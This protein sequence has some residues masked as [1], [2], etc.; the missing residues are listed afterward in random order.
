MSEDAASRLRNYSESP[1]WPNTGLKPTDI[2]G[3]LDE[4][5]RVREELES[6]RRV[7]RLHEK[8]ESIDDFD[9][10]AIEAFREATEQRDAY[11]ERFQVSR[12][13]GRDHE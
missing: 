5:A 9:A 3:V 6:A 4:L 10:E 12:F 8:A 13:G 11:F 1:D 7:I 2:R